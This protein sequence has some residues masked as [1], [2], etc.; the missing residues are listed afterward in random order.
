MSYKTESLLKFS[1]PKKTL[2]TSLPET[3]KFGS[4][5]VNNINR[6]KCDLS[7]SPS[8]KAT[9]FCC[10]RAANFEIRFRN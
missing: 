6:V 8:F 10:P 9:V 3:V 5:R 4:V 2:K 7:L 1:A